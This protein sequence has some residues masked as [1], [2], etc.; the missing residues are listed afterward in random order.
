[1]AVEIT[2][3]QLSDTMDA[4]KILAWNKK[5]GDVVQRG[6]ILA[7]VE[8]DKANLEI[9]SFHNGVLLKIV[10]PVDG[11]AAVGELIAVIGEAGESV[12]ASSPSKAAPQPPA[13]V[14]TASTPPT[15]TP[16]ASV[17]TAV[18]TAAPLAD[19]SATPAPS[20]GRLKAS[21]LAKKIAA[22]RGINLAV[23]QGSGP[24]GRI[25]KRDV[26]DQ[27]SITPQSAPSL[28]TPSSVQQSSQANAATDSTSALSST[29]PSASKPGEAT[30]GGALIPF[31]K[32][33]QT[34]AR[35][36]QQ[37]VNEAP[38]FYV[39]TS[40]LMDNA[41][42]LRKILKERPGYENTSVNHFI[43]KAAA[44]GIVAEPRVNYA[45]RDDQFVFQPEGIN[46]G[47]ITAIEDGLLIPVLK[48]VDTMALQD[49]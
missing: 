17:N 48:N 8:T 29:R 4:G 9:E 39:T 40:I 26:I 15:P 46:I 24:D 18:K 21:P 16:T 19:N 12:G 42:H 14:Q 34:I 13:D 37:S 31:S 20:T 27:G 2:M 47:I 44:Y 23:V 33:R 28:P 6:D 7:E 10:V 5:E 30:S 45:V 32:M 36:M 11:S 3:P 1:M 49:V 22:E 38:H 35:R 43:I 41:V 25:V